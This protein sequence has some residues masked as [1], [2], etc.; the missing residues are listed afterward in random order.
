MTIAAKYPGSSGPPLEEAELLRRAR[1]GELEAFE[2]LVTRQERV[3]YNLARRI[4]GSDEDAQD[5]TQE[6]FLSALEHLP[7]FRGDASIATWLRRIATHAALKV[8]RK[9]QG[10]PTVSLQ[11]L[12]E[13]QEGYDSVPH[14]EYIADW[15]ES[16][17]D[18]LQRRETGGMIEDA[19]Q[20]L[21]EK[22]RLIFLLRDI[23]GLSVRETAEALHLSEPNVKVRLLRARLQLRDQLT[24]AFGDGSKQLLPH[25]HAPPKTLEKA[26]PIPNPDPPVPI[27]VP[28]AYPLL[29]RAPASRMIR[30]C[31]NGANRSRIFC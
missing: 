21:N 3:I 25:R 18:L 1:G 30:S 22:H 15:R 5:V 12:T 29:N 10:L 31:R 4:T 11:A 27:V 8:V 17:A 23:E 26:I 24:R 2:Q 20:T 6:T 19:L 13:P 16:P 28:M 7:N 9:R 14:P